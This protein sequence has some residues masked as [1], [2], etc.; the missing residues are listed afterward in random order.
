MLVKY[1]GFKKDYKY[2]DKYDF[3]KGT[4]EIPNKVAKALITANPKSF[5]TVAP[6]VVAITKKQA[7]IVASVKGVIA[8]SKATVKPEV[9]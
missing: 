4:C 5:I 3:S 9:A 7:A 2:S 1:I 8:G 6:K